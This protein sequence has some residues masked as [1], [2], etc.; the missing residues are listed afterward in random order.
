MVQFLSPETMN[1]H[2][3]PNLFCVCLLL[4]SLQFLVCILMFRIS[5]VFHSAGDLELD[6]P[7]LP[8]KKNLSV[9]IP[10]NGWFHLSITN[11]VVD[12]TE[13]SKKSLM[14]ELHLAPLSSYCPQAVLSSCV[15]SSDSFLHFKAWSAFN[16]GIRK[17]GLLN[18]CSSSSFQHLSMIQFLEFFLNYVVL[19][20]CN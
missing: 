12:H 3:L 20:F 18:F 6:K 19:R 11:L 14:F 9:Y 7:Q 17:I 13:L 8:L 1:L 16:F 15:H 10:S 5:Y 4:A 2:V